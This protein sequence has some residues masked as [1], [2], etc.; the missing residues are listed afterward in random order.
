MPRKEFCMKK[1]LNSDF[2]TQRVKKDSPL[3]KLGQWA[4][5]SPST[6]K[7]PNPV[8]GFPMPASPSLSPQ[9]AQLKTQGPRP[10]QGP[11]LKS[12]MRSKK[13]ELYHMDFKEKHNEVISHSL[14]ELAES[15]GLLRKEFRELKSSVGELQQEL[16][17]NRITTNNQLV[18]LDK[19]LATTSAENLEKIEKLTLK[20]AAI[21]GRVTDKSSAAEGRVQNIVD[22]HSV[23][24]RRSEVRLQEL[25]KMLSEKELRYVRILD[26]LQKARLEI[27]KARTPGPQVMPEPQEI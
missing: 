15:V 27:E 16:H 17:S 20:L 10:T 19:K 5:K 6:P 4:S 22:R 1:T 7:T 3:K 21:S 18:N 11:N 12:P 9:S 2:Q 24:V 25:L 26:S 14:Q 23:S 8:A 13:F